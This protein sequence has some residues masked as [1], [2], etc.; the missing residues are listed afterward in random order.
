MEPSI[1]KSFFDILW[2]LTG[3][4]AQT[5]YIIGGTILLVVG[6]VILADWLRWKAKAVEVEGEI[7]GLKPRGDVFLPV[8]RYELDGETLEA[9]SRTGSSSIKGQETGT[10]V[11]IL[12]LRSDPSRAQPARA[13]IWPL[14]GL[15]LAAPGLYM[16]YMAF[17]KYEVNGFTWATLAMLGFVSFNR[18][19]R[20]VIPKSQR[21]SREEWRLQQRM[22]VDSLPIYTTEDIR[23]SPQMARREAR[24]EKAAAVTGPLLVLAGAAAIAGALYFGSNML[25][26][27]GAETAQGQVIQLAGNTDGTYQAVVKFTAEGRDITFRDKLATQPAMYEEG[28]QVGVLY[29]KDKIEETAVIDR[30]ILNWL[31]AAALGVFG[32]LFLLGGI[33]RMPRSRDEAL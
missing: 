7:I 27:V 5:G 9:T 4:F 31:P 16:V 6:G 20:S 8:Y 14:I 28:E 29:Q 13:A 30:G 33:A 25:D 15:L 10:R 23:Q 17:T 19:R 1:E 22:E 3:A 2:Q 12:I 26:L 18:F 11:T 21:L 32:I 24:A